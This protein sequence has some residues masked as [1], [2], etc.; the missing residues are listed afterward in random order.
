[1]TGLA[2]SLHVNSNAGS[3]TVLEAG[4]PIVLTSAATT[5]TR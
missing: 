1:M 3:V 2:L 5:R 4:Q